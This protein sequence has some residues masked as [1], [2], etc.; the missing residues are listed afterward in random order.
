MT[1]ESSPLFSDTFAP[2]LGQKTR[3]WSIDESESLSLLAAENPNIRRAAYLLRDAT[4]LAKSTS[5]F[6]HTDVFLSVKPETQ[7]SRMFHRIL[8]SSFV[9]MYLRLCVTGIVLLSFVEPPSWCRNIQGDGDGSCKTI[10]SAQGIPAFYSDSSEAKF[11][12]YYPNTGNVWFTVDQSVRIEC[13]FVVMF[14]LHLSLCFATADF[15]IEKFFYMG[16]LRSDLDKVSTRRNRNAYMFRWIRIVALFFYVKGIFSFSNGNPQRPFASLL[17]MLLF[18]TYS[19]GLQ[20]EIV[21]VME[22]IPALVSVVLVLVLVI[23][24]FGLIGVAAF[25]DSSEGLKHFS[26]FIEG[27]VH[28]HF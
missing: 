20:M 22:I 19:E 6:A 13:F 17:R 25:Y 11:Q 21:T 16:F 14:L 9:Q 3:T 10:M 7:V 23:A 5:S 1:S 27:N 12:Q 28:S 24:F 8:S 2:Y 4:L 26:N 18:I 15:S